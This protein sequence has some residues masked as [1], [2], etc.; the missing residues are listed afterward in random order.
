MLAV[1]DAPVRHLALDDAGLVRGRRPGKRFNED[2]AA[3]R[4]MGGYGLWGEIPGGSV[5]RRRLRANL[6]P[7]VG[8]DIVLE[9]ASCNTRRIA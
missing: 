2:P 9:A 3:R 4:I 8:V 1:F 6:G 7:G 5:L